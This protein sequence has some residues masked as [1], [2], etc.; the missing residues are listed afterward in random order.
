MSVN[1]RRTPPESGGVKPCIVHVNEYPLHI[2]KRHLLQCNLVC[3]H[4][5]ILST[6]PLLTRLRWWAAPSDK[7]TRPRFNWVQVHV[8]FLS[9]VKTKTN[10]T[11]FSATT[12]LL[13]AGRI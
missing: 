4:D 10:Q 8:F 11:E 13:D 6:A 9:R 1:E 2:M 7:Q 5:L 12:N 3:G